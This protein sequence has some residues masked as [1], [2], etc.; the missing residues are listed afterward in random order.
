LLIAIALA[1]G[2]FPILFF[3]GYLVWQVLR[4][5]LMF[6]SGP[7]VPD[8]W[9]LIL[10]MTP[11]AAS[12]L[13]VVGFLYATFVCVVVLPAVAL[14][15]R[16]LDWRPCW[17][18]LGIFCG[19]LVAY[20]ATLPASLYAMGDTLP[21]DAYLLEP[22]FSWMAAPGLA[23]WIGQF[24]GGLAG[25]RNERSERQ[26]AARQSASSPAAQTSLQFSLWQILA[27]MAIASGLLTLLRLSDLLTAPMLAAT[28]AWLVLLVLGRRPAHCLAR[29]FELRKLCKR[30]IRRQNWRRKFLPSTIPVAAPPR[31]STD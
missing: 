2:C 21:P 9:M 28:G 14:S 7:T 31:S 6:F 30:R 8:E 5:P 1:G 20:I 22:A 24:G 11:V 3:V 10:I 15:L 18:G 27:M 19:G 16:L 23:I 13:F 26:L 29:R 4:Y 12:V 17:T 25:I